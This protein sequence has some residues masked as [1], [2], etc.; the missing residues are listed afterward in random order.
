MVQVGPWARRDGMDAPETRREPPLPGPLDTQAPP[1]REPLSPNG[2]SANP[3][4]AARGSGG[5]GWTLAKG[6]FI[7]GRGVEVSP[8][9]C[10]PP[11]S[12]PGRCLLNLPSS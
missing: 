3:G 2:G 11:V 12:H 5:E 9:F 8:C 7:S 10:L 4:G 1:S 6:H